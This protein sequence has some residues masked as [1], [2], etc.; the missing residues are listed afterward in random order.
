MQSVP[1]LTPPSAIFQL[2]RGGQ[3]YWWGKKGYL[4]KTTDL[5][6]VTDKLYQI[7]YN[8]PWAWF[9]LTISVVT[10]TDCIGRCKSNYHTITATTAPNLMWYSN[11]NDYHKYNI[12]NR[13]IFL[14]IIGSL[15][16]KESVVFSRYPFFPHQYNW[17]P[18]YNWNIAEGGVKHHKTNQPKHEIT[19]NPDSGSYTHES[20]DSH[21]S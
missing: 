8:T 18:R 15:K 21:G 14:L 1:G 12:F 7:M 6:Q 16:F 9:D 17:P 19:R 2:Y 13:K 20:I 3:L 4:E 5:P 11:I 10:G